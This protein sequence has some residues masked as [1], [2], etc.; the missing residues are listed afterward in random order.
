MS[1]QVPPHLDAEVNALLAHYP[2]EQK[3]SAV[4][5]V[6]HAVQEQCGCVSDAM[7]E[8]VAA[9]LGCQPIHVYE[10]VTFY[11]MFRRKRVGK[12]HIK[13]C[14]TL[15]CELAGSHK[16]SETLQKTVGTG[17]DQTTPDGKF[18]IS[19]VECL[20]ACGTGPCL[21]IN[22]DFHEKVTKEK[23]EQLLA[24]LK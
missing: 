2:P 19:W 22:D 15:S 8:W 5:M 14:R 24:N 4:L 20:A 7:V 1:A 3:R 13:I 10:C 16:L 23:A 17:M 18:T 21:M 6:L 9:K 12:Y 11:P